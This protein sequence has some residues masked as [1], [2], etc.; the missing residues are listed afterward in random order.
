MSAS[1]RGQ[2][3]YPHIERTKVGGESCR[4]RRRFDAEW[5]DIVPLPGSAERTTQNLH[6]QASPT[7]ELRNLKTRTENSI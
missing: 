4:T 2:R 1:M 7:G 3:R 6:V 5:Q